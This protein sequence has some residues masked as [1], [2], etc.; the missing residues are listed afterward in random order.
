MLR[1][2]EEHLVRQVLT[3]YI[4]DKLNDYPTGSILMNAPNHRSIDELIDLAYD[5]EQWN[6][7]VNA[8]SWVPATNSRKR[9]ASQVHEATCSSR[10]KRKLR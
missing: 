1:E 5:R 9:E 10:R 8:I 4:A 3:R 6:L 2:K 7:T